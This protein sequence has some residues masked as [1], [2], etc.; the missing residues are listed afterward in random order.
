MR[1]VMEAVME[2]AMGAVKRAVKYAMPAAVVWLLL[3]AT[4]SQVAAADAA[5]QREQLRARIQ[6]ERER[7]EAR[8]SA[9]MTACQQRFVVTACAEDASQR[10]REALA[11]PRA[12]AFMLDDM[13]RRERAIA[14]R[15]AVIAKQREAASRPAPPLPA[16]APLDRVRP[17]APEAS[18]TP[19]RGNAGAAASAAS[20]EALRRAQARRVR[21]AEIDAT[22][23]RIRARQ[24]ERLRDGK[25]AAPLPVPAASR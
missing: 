25:A 24:V 3:A 6:A 11:G 1:A 18:P 7:I 13:E 8:F 23:E 20:T 4:P 10:R 14:R 2:A 21:Q 5:E 12:Q 16:S 22:Q 15:E 19:G 17:A 9:E